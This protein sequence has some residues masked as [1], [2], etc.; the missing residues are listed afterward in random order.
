MVENLGTFE[1]A[2]ITKSQ[3]KEHISGFCSVGTIQEVTEIE[4]GVNVAAILHTEQNEFFLKMHS[5]RTT[6]DQF[7]SQPLV[8]EYL[9]SGINTAFNT[10]IPIGYDYTC[11]DFQYKFYITTAI[12]G[13]TFDTSTNPITVEKA[14]AAGRVL[15]QINSIQA[16]GIGYTVAPE[17]MSG[18]TCEIEPKLPFEECDWEEEY[19]QSVRELTATADP[20]FDDLQPAIQEYITEVSIRN[21]DPH[22]LHFDYWWENILWDDT[23][24]PYVIDWE[25]SI[26]GDPLANEI[27]AEHLLFDSLTIDYEGLEDSYA[28]NRYRM[29]DEFRSAYWDAYS[30]SQELN[31]DKETIEMYEL[32]PYLKE[33]R[34]FPYWWRHKD[35]DWKKDREEALRNHIKSYIK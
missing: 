31:A 19:K 4:D 12:D 23:D 8:L 15:G 22:L 16:P 5:F 1:D 13:D 3:L 21:P 10:P 35:E 24:E 9:N 26:G 28:S 18:P 30:G 20:R 11:S 2:G 7:K 17:N 32:L 33:L 29:R 34:G 14:R 6:T 25:R 27:L